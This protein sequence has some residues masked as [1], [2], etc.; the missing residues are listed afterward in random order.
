MNSTRTTTSAS[1]AILR[2]QFIRST[3]LI[4]RSSSSSLNH[5]HLYRKEIMMITAKIASPRPAAA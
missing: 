5:V 3:R 2:T 4:N 1:T